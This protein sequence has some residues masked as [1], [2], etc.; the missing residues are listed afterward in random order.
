MNYEEAIAWLGGMRS[1][2]NSIPYDPFDTYQIRIAQADAAMMQQAYYVAM[3]Y[4]M[5]RIRNDGA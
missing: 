1:M 5:D 4:R 2:A 3:F